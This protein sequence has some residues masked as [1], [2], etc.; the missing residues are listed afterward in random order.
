[1]TQFDVKNKTEIRAKSG[2][3]NKTN[4]KASALALFINETWKWIDTF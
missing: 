4:F 3:Q 2:A 1:M